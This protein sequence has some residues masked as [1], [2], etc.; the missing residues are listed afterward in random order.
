MTTRHRTRVDILGYNSIL[1]IKME[2]YAVT[3]PLRCLIA[4]L[5]Y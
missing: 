2:P 5:A 3:V 4:Q 1:V